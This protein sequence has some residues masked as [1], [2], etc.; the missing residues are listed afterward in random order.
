[1]GI[2]R[3]LTNNKAMNGQAV[4][5]EAA[6]EAWDVFSADPRT[7]WIFTPERSH[8]MYFRR[9]VMGRKSTPN[10]WT[11]AWL[12]AGKDVVRGKAGMDL[13]RQVRIAAGALVLVGTLLSLFVHPA[14]IGLAIFVGAG[15]VFAGI[16][17][18]CGM[19]LLLARMPWNR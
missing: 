9:F 11:D 5:P 4:S 15:L 17:N 6:L 10:F 8:E 7:T 18:F 2:L 14:L 13:E 12:A 19:G 16:S 3:L 1:M